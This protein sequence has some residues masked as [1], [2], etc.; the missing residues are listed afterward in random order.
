MNGAIVRLFDA[1]RRRRIR[2]K[3]ALAAS[4]RLGSDDAAWA[5]LFRRPDWKAPPAGHYGRCGACGARIDLSVVRCGDC[6]AEWRP[7]KRRT[8][9]YRQILVYGLALALSALSGHA[10]ASWV[11]T[12]FG[13][14]AERGDAANPEMVETLSSFTWLFCGVMMMIGLT[15]AI[16]RL[17][18]TG[19]WRK[20]KA[21]P[22]EGGGRRR[23]GGRS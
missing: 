13:R 1:W 15:F 10:G 11:R 8:D 12:S 21:H 2:H 4:E 20:A 5:E 19:H 9:L 16:E 3:E 18:P 6:G 22:P 7:N 14:A 17:A 23:R